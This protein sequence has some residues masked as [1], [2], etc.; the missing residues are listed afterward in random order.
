M[1]RLEVSQFFMAS[2]SAKSDKLYPSDKGMTLY[3]FCV[4]ESYYST[5]VFF[6]YLLPW[7]FVGK[8]LDQIQRVMSLIPGQIYMQIISWHIKSSTAS[9]DRPL[10]I[11]VDLLCILLQDRALFNLCVLLSFL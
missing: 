9:D 1:I 11:Y 6:L 7:V 2:E 5:T 8:T 10:G 3:E 4:H